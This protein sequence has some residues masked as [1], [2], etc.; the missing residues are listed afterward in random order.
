VIGFRFW[1][2]LFGVFVLVWGA[3]TLVIRLLMIAIDVSWWAL[4]A[5]V[6]GVWLVA[7]SLRKEGSAKL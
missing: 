5:I 3:V 4:F 6:V 1:P 7:F 2:F